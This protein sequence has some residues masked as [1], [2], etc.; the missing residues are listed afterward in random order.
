MCAISCTCSNCSCSRTSNLSESVSALIS[1]THSRFS[2]CCNHNQ[3]P[4]HILQRCLRISDSPPLLARCSIRHCQVLQTPDATEYAS[5]QLGSPVL[6][7]GALKTPAETLIYSNIGRLTHLFRSWQRSGTHTE[8]RNHH[9]IHSGTHTSYLVPE[10][11]RSSLCT[12]RDS[13]VEAE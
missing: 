12:Y 1:L 8:T 13:K 10:N 9:A 3:S 2:L 5:H 4:L 7:K 11:A 6:L